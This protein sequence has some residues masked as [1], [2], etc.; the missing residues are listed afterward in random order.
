MS[1][2]PRDLKS[3]ELK[4]GRLVA[5]YVSTNAFASLRHRYRGQGGDAFTSQLSQMDSQ[6]MQATGLAVSLLLTHVDLIRATIYAYLTHISL[7]TEHNRRLDRDL[8][9]VV[10]F[11]TSSATRYYHPARRASLAGYAYPGSR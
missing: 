7:P 11:P 10:A 9:H 2:N 4:E 3:R 8:Q 1:P 6:F 5:L